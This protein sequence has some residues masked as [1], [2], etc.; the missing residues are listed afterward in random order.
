MADSESWHPGVQLRLFGFEKATRMASAEAATEMER[1]RL[2]SRVV[3]AHQALSALPEGDELA[4]LHS[5]L[6]QTYLPHSRPHDSTEAWRRHSGRFTLIVQPGLVDETRDGGGL[7]WLGVPYGARARLILIYLQSEAVARGRE[8]TLG[9]S[10]TAWMRSLGIE[11]TGGAKGTIS[12]VR[13]QTLRIARCLFTLQFDGVDAEGRPVRSLRDIKIA[14]GLDLAATSCDGLWPRSVFLGAAFYEHLREHAVPLDKRAVAY[15]AGNSLGLDLYAL[16][17]YRLPRLK[18]DLQ[19]R[20]VHL[21]EQLGAAEKSMSNL[22]KRI[23]EV[24]PNVAAAY[25]EARV[26]I[27]RH[28]L[29]L[30]PSPASVPKPIVTGFR[31]ISG[32]RAKA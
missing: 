27:T 8:V 18:A 11:P 26:E 6:C 25:P 28:G 15:L 1:Q 13:E 9:A 3:T 22:A 17:A 14:D 7:R 24:M 20:W 4:F 32:G 10:F 31:L 5:G 19:L 16:F 29:V 2:V 30:K 23:R 21:A 12:H